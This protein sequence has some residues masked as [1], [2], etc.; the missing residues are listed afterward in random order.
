LR[1]LK[2]ESKIETKDGAKSEILFLSKLS[3][4]GEGM[5]LDVESID[6]EFS[7]ETKFLLQTDRLEF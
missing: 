2:S 4:E 7:T 3:F 6:K 1:T 5:T